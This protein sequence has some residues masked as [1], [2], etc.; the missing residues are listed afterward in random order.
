MFFSLLPLAFAGSVSV[1]A[2]LPAFSLPSVDGV[3]TASTSFVGEPTVVNVWASWCRPCL[4]ELPQLDGLRATWPHWRFVGIAL[5]PDPATAR[6]LLSKQ[7]VGMLTLT[8]PTGTLFDT[9]G[10]N[11]VPA[12]Y[13]LDAQGVV[14][15]VRIGA[16]S[17]GSLPDFE[18]AMRAVAAP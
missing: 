5:D 11:A 13:V 12:T 15:V 3:T 17:A 7:H 14:R 18:A 10:L 6:S 16:V 1:G 9:L 2:A 8:D 4:A